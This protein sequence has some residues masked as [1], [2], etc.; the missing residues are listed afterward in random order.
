MMFEPVVDGD[1]VPARPIERIVAGAGADV[2]LMLGTT[3]EEWRF[4]LVPGGAIDR[5]TDDRLVTTARVMGLDAEHALPV[6]RGSRPQASPGDLLAAL[7]TDWFFHI[8]A[9]RLAE[10]HANNGGSPYVYEFARRSP[11]FNG[12]FGAVHALEIGFVFDNLGREGAMTVAGE[13]PPQALADAM[14]RA[15]VS[16]AS[17]GAPG[18]SPYDVGERSVMRFDGSGGTVVTDPAAQERQVWNGI[19]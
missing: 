9:I 10:A 3:T 8:P 12:R 13:A 4:F 14:H 16:F 5:V 18:W 1:V 19:R 6:Y 17:S 15:W 7:I 11:L 2:D